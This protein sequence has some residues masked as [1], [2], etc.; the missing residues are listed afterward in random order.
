M[1][2]GKRVICALS[3]ESPKDL[4]FIKRLVE[5]GKII[6]LVDKRFPLEKTADAHRY[7]EKGYKTGSVTITVEH[8]NNK[9]KL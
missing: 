5:E 1:T 7:V 9:E 8:N 2:G 3:S 4:A 6:S